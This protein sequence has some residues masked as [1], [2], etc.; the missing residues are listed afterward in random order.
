[1]TAH[2]APLQRAILTLLHELLDGPP[3]DVAFVLNPGDRGLL[4]SLATLSADA[5]SARPGGR[6][7]VAAHVDHVRY[8]FELLN[9][10][11]RG[12][13]PWAGA[14]YSASW[15]RQE[16]SDEG[17]R[18]LREALASESHAWMA[19]A[20]RIRDASD[21]EWTGVLASA[22]HLAYHLGAIRQIAPSAS[23]PPARD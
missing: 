16:V 3:G 5:A 23:G 20:E 11:S 1:M 9:R 14:D 15:A 17:W 18:A 12:E 7:S 6:A 13:D 19:A 8:G 2:Q 4:T 21:V 10:W 22:V